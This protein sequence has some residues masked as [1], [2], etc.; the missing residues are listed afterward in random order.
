M[1]WLKTLLIAWFEELMSQR[2]GETDKASK[3]AM[4]RVLA[5]LFFAGIFL[6][7]V[8]LVYQR[9]ASG[10]LT[11]MMT[12]VPLARSEQFTLSVLMHYPVF[13]V[14]ALLAGV[15]VLFCLILLSLMI[16]EL[17][18]AFYRRNSGGVKVPTKTENKMQGENP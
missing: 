9:L 13:I 1:K 8:G 6:S 16:D 11:S 3:A 7:V 5:R 2:N 15:V 4:L 18:C 14:Q 10:M 17:A 12:Q